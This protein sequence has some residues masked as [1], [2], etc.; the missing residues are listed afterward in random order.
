MANQ[1]NW[2][3]GWGLILSGLFYLTPAIAAAN[4]A[5]GPMAVYEVVNVRSDDTLAVR[6][7]PGVKYH[8]IAELA[9]NASG[10]HITGPA[11]QVGASKWVPI[12][13]SQHNGWVNQRFLRCF[14]DGLYSVPVHGYET[15]NIQ[16]FQQA[17]AQA[18]TQQEA[19]TYDVVQ[20]A[21][22]FLGG[23]FEGQT[24]LITQQNTDI[25]GTERAIVTIIRDGY[26]DDQIRGE[27]FR[28]IFDRQQNIWQ[29]QHVERAWRCWNGR[30]DFAT[31]TCQAEG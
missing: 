4:H 23:A 28:F 20:I 31:G 5:C 16:P 7:G 8:K 15:L 27:R 1:C 2:V 13:Y 3:I 24:Q 6:E 14:A 19:W 26:L 30:T 12:Q 21:V 29:L 11:S 22:R 9:Y 18:L 25:A 10:I 17:F